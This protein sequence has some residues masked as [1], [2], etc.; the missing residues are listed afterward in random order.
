MSFIRALVIVKGVV[1]GVGFRYWCQRK[2]VGL[3][4]RG[5]VGNLSDGTVEVSFEGDRSL[6]EAMIEELKVGPTYSHVTDVKIDWFDE[7]KGYDNFSIE[8]LNR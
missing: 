1:Q 5:Y 2:A 7:P 4:L 3:G 8:M 6:V